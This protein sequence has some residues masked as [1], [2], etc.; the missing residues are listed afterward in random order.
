MKDWL[1]PVICLRESIIRYKSNQR[2]GWGFFP[3]K[4]SCEPRMYQEQHR[5]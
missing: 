1:I 4:Y 2:E 3:P 5:W